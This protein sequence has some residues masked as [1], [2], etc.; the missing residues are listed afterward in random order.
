M[1]RKILVPLVFVFVFLV[2]PPAIYLL[3]YSQTFTMQQE[4]ISYTLPYPGIL[5]D[6][7]LYFIKAIRDQLLQMRTR[8]NIKKAEVYLLLSDKRVAMTL[9][10]AKK[11]KD[12]L[13]IT[14]F[15]KGEKYFSYIPKLLSDSKKQGV[16][17][18]SDFVNTLKL[19][20]SKH[21]EVAETLL[22]EL[23]QGQNEAIGQILKMN[24]EIKTELEKL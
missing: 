6:H 7:P 23:P 16:S 20:N 5:P 17:A 14:T 21:R 10:L 12:K 2:I 3:D 18:Q 8:D 19:S 1:F 11:G 9:S 4:K 15:S 13:A 22:K 24:A